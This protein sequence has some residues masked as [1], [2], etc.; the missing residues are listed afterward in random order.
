M[1]LIRIVQSRLQ[2]CCRVKLEAVRD[3]EGGV[4]AGGMGKMF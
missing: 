4:W 2:H 1:K 3:G